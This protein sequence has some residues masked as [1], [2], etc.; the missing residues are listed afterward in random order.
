MLRNKRLWK[1]ANVGYFF[2]YMTWLH[3]Q[4]ISFLSLLLF[5]TTTVMTDFT[6]VINICSRYCLL[7]CRCYR[8]KN[9]ILFSDRQHRH[10]VAQYF[11]LAMQSNRSAVDAINWTQIEVTT[12]S[13][14]KAVE[15]TNFRNARSFARQRR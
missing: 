4:A 6:F 11:D 12:M 13:K 1:K 14:K 10:F 7:S 5:T 9:K 8:M 15:S 3:S 2:Y